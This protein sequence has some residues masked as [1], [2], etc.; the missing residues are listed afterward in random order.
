[1]NLKRKDVFFI[2]VVSIIALVIFTYG[3]DA[4]DKYGFGVVEFQ[5]DKLYEYNPVSSEFECLDYTI[6]NI[7][8]MEPRDV[9]ICN[10]GCVIHP[11]TT[12]V[13]YRHNDPFAN[14]IRCKYDG[15]LVYLD[16]MDVV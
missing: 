7:H 1:M 2:L 12:W 3:Y 13:L 6:N 8:Q 4:A 5:T 11:N 14:L 15:D 16:P 10:D 9:L